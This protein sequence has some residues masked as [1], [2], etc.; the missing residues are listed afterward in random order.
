MQFLR[1][2]NEDYKCAMCMFIVTNILNY[3]LNIYKILVHISSGENFTFF[4]I[5][6][7]SIDIYQTGL[8]SDNYHKCRLQT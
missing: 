7:I 3:I 1:K 5:L 6:T 4:N 2:I 8:D